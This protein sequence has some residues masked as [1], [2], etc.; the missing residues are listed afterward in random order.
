MLK[1]G[2]HVSMSGKKML[3][4]SVEEMLSYD[5]NC[6][7]MYT[8]APQNTRRKDVSELKIEEAKELLKENNLSMDNVIVHA[9]YIIN[10]ANTTKPETFEIAVSF[11][12][13]EIKRVEAIGAKY[14]VLHPGSHVGAGEE[15]GLNQII[16]GLNLVLT[17]EQ[18]VVVC[19]ETMAGKGKGSELGNTF[20]QLSYIIKNVN[21]PEKLGVCM[22][23]CHMHDSGYDLTNFDKILDEFDEIVGIEY[24]KCMHINDTKNDIGAAKDRHENLGYGE[25]GFDTLSRIVNHPRLENVVKILETPYINDKKDAPYKQEIE[26]LRNQKFEDWLDEERKSK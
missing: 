4:G 7:M 18:D 15:V 11:L 20:E 3:L 12:K 26:M 17:Q 13:E 2:S 19:L 9:P 23:T 6:M 5:A 16:K 24:L 21:L 10:L 22:D 25:I 14:I 1:I 8:G